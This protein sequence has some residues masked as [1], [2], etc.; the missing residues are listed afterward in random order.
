MTEDEIRR[1]YYVYALIDPRNNQPFYIGK[2]KG[3]R[4]RE[5]YMPFSLKTRAQKNSTIKSYR[6][7][8]FE[9]KYTIYQDNLSDEQAILLEKKYIKLFGRRVDGG[10]LTNYNIDG[11][12]AS[13]ER[14]QEWK[15]AISKSKKAKP[16]YHSRDVVERINDTWR[17]QKH[18][19]DV[20]AQIS[21]ASKKQMEDPKKKAQALE[22]LVKR[23]KWYKINLSNGEIWVVFNL[24]HFCDSLGLSA[25]CMGAVIRKTMHVHKGCTGEYYTPTE[26]DL[27]D[28]E[29]SGN[30]KSFKKIWLGS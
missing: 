28:Y 12:L 2:G 8:G 10:C 7:M 22:N 30:P 1:D 3:P 24:K 14:T 4:V 29:R 5:H 9:D 25:A 27:K 19:T 23:A 21:A 15:D 11:T 16:Y 6:K 13:L 17:G 18:P 26:E 20:I